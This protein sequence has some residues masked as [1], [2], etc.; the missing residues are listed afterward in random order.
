MDF[1]FGKIVR[2]ERLIDMIFGQNS[3]FTVAQLEERQTF[4]LED[5]VQ[6]GSRGKF[7]FRIFCFHFRLTAI[8]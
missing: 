4:D 8:L 2:F 1:F 3:F 6:M 5:P 7:F